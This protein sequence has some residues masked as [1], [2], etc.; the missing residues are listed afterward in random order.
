MIYDGNAEELTDRDATPSRFLRDAAQKQII[1]IAAHAVTAGDTPKQSYLL[2]ARDR[3]GTGLLDAQT[4][5]NSLHLETTRL[6]V[7]GA[8]RS[9]GSVTVGPQGVAPLVRPFLAAGVPGVIGTL[10]DIN[11]ATARQV[12]VSFHRHYRDGSDAAAALRA[13]QIELLQDTNPGL[14][15][16]LTWGAY[17]AIGFASSPFPSAGEMKKEKPP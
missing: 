12:L 4:L 14:S 3:S 13:A 11:D 17:Q 8:C 6:V 10:W 2:M 16:E 5:L 7:L 15:S 9:G 1:H